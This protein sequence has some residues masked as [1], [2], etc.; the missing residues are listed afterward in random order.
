MHAHLRRHW[1]GSPAD[2]ARFIRTSARLGP[3]GL[4]LRC[5]APLSSTTVHPAPPGPTPQLWESEVVEWFVAGPDG[6]TEIELGPFGNHLV[7]RFSAYRQKVDDLHPIA[8][9]ARITA[10]EN[11]RRWEGR[12]LV[13]TALL[14]EG[15]LRINVCAIQPGPVYLQWRPARGERPDFHDL[16]PATALR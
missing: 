16:R 11:G 15:P 4:A 2:P 1:D 6:Y 10:D 5:V 9:Q 3:D 7:L 14:P 13:P 12:A 8:Y